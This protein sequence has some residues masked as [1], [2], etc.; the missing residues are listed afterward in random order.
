M[1]K[2]H[3]PNLRPGGGDKIT[4]PGGGADVPTPEEL[5]FSIQ[6]ICRGTAPWMG[7]RSDD[8][9]GGDHLQNISIYV[10]VRRGEV[11]CRSQ[12]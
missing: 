3:N 1:G 2:L 6:M 4:D 12:D 10:S 8:L 11:F 9:Q 7:E 5:H